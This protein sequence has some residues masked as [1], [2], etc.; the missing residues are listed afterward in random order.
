MKR[1][2]WYVV[3]TLILILAGGAA[4]VEVVGAVGVDSE[5]SVT[6]GCAV[7]WVG[8][9]AEGTFGLQPRNSVSIRISAT[10]TPCFM[11][12]VIIRLLRK[13]KKGSAVS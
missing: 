9:S 10:E 8:G 3:G 4:V 1:S 11:T 6:A 5:V 13:N 7:S 2:F 12:T